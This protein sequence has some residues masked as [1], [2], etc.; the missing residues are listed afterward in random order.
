M[1]LLF[2]HGYGSQPGGINPDVPPR[3]WA[4]GRQRALPAAD[5]EES[6][7]IA[8][9]AFDEGKPE[10]VVGSSRG[11]AVALNIDTGS[12]PPVLVAPACKC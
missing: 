11:D 6:V 4:S 8:Q 2:L 3:T 12:T 9:H 1:K 7:R 10:V 5:I